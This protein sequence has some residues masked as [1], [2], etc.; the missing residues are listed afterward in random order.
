MFN[1]YD[2]GGYLIYR[3]YGDANGDAN[4]PVFIYGEA[5]ELGNQL[6]Q[7]VSDVENA[8]PDWQTILTEHGVNYVVER[9]DSALS[10]ALGVDP[11]W[12]RVYDDGFAV[13][14]VKR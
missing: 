9:T 11:Q 1:A 6:L 3:F 7:E 12:K 5:T 14:F 2:W 8:E 10:M 4:R 13:I